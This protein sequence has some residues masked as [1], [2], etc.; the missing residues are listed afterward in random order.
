MRAILPLLIA[1][2]G[3]A[4]CGTA[5]GEGAERPSVMFGD[6]CAKCHGEDA[7]GKPE[8]A[9]PGIA[10]L[11]DWYVAAQLHKY[12]KGIRGA[13]AADLEGLR[14]R[15]MS[16]TIRET[17]VAPIAAYVSS[18]APAPEE[19]ERVGDPEKGK[20]HYATCAACH[21][22]DGKGM[23]ALN[24]P[25]IAMMPSWY[26]KTQLHKFRSGVRGAHPDDITGAQMVPMAKAIPNDEAVADLAAYVSTL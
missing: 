25:P 2:L 9:A 23:Q 11:P 13:H 24:A 20:A 7:H 26:I 8:I 1:A 5:A 6:Q 15:P 14:M 19:T 22:P 3:A 17:D 12:R 10:G 4:G 16:R 18:L 21:G